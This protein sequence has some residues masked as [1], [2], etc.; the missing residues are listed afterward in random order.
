MCEEKIKNLGF[1]ESVKVDYNHFNNLVR[2]FKT[3][4]GFY[5][6]RCIYL[7]KICYTY[8]IKTVIEEEK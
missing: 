2:T 1:T 3:E 5:T 7:L 4:Y 8:F 6:N